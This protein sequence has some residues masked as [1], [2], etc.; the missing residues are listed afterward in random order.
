MEKKIEEELAFWN[1][2][3]GSF[4]YLVVYMEREEPKDL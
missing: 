4:G 2:E 1:L 3:V